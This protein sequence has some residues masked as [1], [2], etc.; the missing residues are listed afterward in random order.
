MALLEQGAPAASDGQRFADGADFDRA[1]HQRF[2][3]SASGPSWAGGPRSCGHVAPL[4]GLGSR[5]RQA[6]CAR[7]GGDLSI[8]RRARAGRSCTTS[9]RKAW[10]RAR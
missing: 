7:A 8:T 9:T 5:K 3:D 10:R 4:A 2:C 6:R 1:R